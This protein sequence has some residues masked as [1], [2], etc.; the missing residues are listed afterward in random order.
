MSWRAWSLGFLAG[1]ALA[2]WL[3]LSCAPG[4]AQSA[5]VASALDH[6]AAT[7]GVSAGC[8]RRIAYRESRYLPWATTA[9]SGA[10]GLMQFMG[11]TWRWMSAQ[12]GYGGA[13]PYDAWS[14]AHVA[15]WAIS[16]GY[17]SHW[18]GWC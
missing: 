18:G 3:T 10:A 9:R 16:R 8:L 4:S 6:A 7:Y 14:A 1:A 13:S 17:L 15:G 5:E 12:A 2:S 11:P